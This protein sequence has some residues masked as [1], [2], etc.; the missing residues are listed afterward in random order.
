MACKEAWEAAFSQA[1]CLKAWDQIGISP[2]TQRVLWDLLDA[3][4]ARKEVADKQ[5]QEGG[6]QTTGTQPGEAESQGPLELASVGDG[7]LRRS[8][9]EEDK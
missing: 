9:E 6:G 8:D 5:K 3:D 1:N 4:A 2:F 7:L